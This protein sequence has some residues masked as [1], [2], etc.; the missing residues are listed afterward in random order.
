MDLELAGKR[1]L[2]TGASRGIGLAIARRLAGEGARVAV[3]AAHSHERLDAAA[4]EIPGSVP[5][6]ADVSDP[7]AVEAMF[8][9]VKAELGGLDILVNNAAVTRDSLLMMMRP[10]AWREVLAVDLDGAVHCTRHALRAMIGARHGRI[11][12]VI[13]PAAFLGKPG[14]SN[15]AAAKGA[16]VALTKSLAAE[17][18]RHAI[19]VNAV[20]PGYVMT[21]LVAGMSDSER[22][23][24]LR[25]IP[26]GRFGA[27]EDV[28]DAVA[29][30]ASARASYVSGTTLVVDGGLT[31]L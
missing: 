24:W 10:E 30:L 25:R 22:A 26:L 29:F 8:Q 12:N 23:D 9:R 7:A 2:V 16:L 15:Y 13:S 6:F 31:M 4:A 3:N 28:A 21:D 18:G 27:P 17:A 11:V 19:T 5:C 20:C 14:A 1:A